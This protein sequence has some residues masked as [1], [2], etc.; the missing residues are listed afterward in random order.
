MGTTVPPQP[1]KLFIGL[2]SNNESLF[3]PVARE[4]SGLFGPIDRV[5]PPFPFSH[6]RYYEEEF[7]KDLKRRFVFFKEPI[8]P[9]EIVTI[10]EKTNSLEDRWAVQ[11]GKG[12]K[13]RMNIDPGY[14]NTV[15]VVL[16]ST[17]DVAHRIYLADGIYAEVTLVYRYGRFQVLEHTYPDFRSDAA[18]DLFTGVR[19]G[20]LGG[21]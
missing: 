8:S 7:G 20:L 6:T 21:P 12:R 5:S 15:K 14:L 2:L 18:L 11:T 10:K 17:K 19:N 4:C 16:V 13:R 1:V 3:D 9:G